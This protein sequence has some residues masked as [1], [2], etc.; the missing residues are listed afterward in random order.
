MHG[1][2][3]TKNSSSFARTSRLRNTTWP[4]ASAPWA[5]KARFAIS[6]PIVLACPTDASS[7]GWS[8]PPLWHVD[9]V[10]GRPH[11]H[12][13][14]TTRCHP[15]KPP[16][17][18]MWHMSPTGLWS[19]VDALCLYRRQS[20]SPM[21]HDVGSISGCGAA[22]MTC[23]ASRNCRSP[24]RRMNQH[25]GTDGRQTGRSAARYAPTCGAALVQ[26]HPIRAFNTHG[27]SPTTWLCRSHQPCGA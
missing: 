8:T 10:G 13:P 19:G 3:A 6:N 17:H 27:G 9:A 1:G 5:W 26:N 22:R 14:D 21:R 2:W 4:D 15:P 12:S 23:Q 18:S 7:S 24:M 16:R 11:H 25:L 20:T